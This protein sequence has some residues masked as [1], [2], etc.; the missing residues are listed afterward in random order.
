MT[1]HTDPDGLLTSDQTRTGYVRGVK[2][3]DKFNVR[4]VEYSEVGGQAVF[5]GC[6]LLGTIDQMEVLKTQVEASPGVDFLNVAEP[7]GITV[8]ARNLWPKGILPY[9]VDPALPDQN[10]VAEAI[11]HWEQKTEIRFVER[12]HEK[13]YVSFV[14]GPG[15]A[16]EVGRVG[17]EQ[18]VQLGPNCTTGN[19]IH[20]I[21][22]AL[23]LWHEQSRS[24]RDDYVQVH[25]EN[26][27]DSAIH[28]FSQMLHEG[29]DRGPY[30]TASIMHCGTHFFSKNGQPT[31]AAKNSAPIGQ[32]D[33]L[34]EGDIAAIAEAYA[35]EIKK[36]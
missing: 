22:H 8:L 2:G 24:D 1:N 11:N 34:S 18:V 35:S 28:N 13:D 9:R 10:R 19:T 12:T 14:P 21:G 31:I 5:E 36:R 17:G 15:C 26:V 30:D 6:I 20:E 3:A 33:G 16:A 4:K 23:G 32:R 7:F 27:M 25:L 29:V